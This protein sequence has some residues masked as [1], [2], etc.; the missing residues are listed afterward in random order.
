MQSRSFFQLDYAAEMEETSLNPTFDENRFVRILFRPAWR[1]S[2]SYPG[3]VTGR[4][5]PSD[6]SES[7]SMSQKTASKPT[8]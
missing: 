5:M 2:A 8:R 4:G 6:N 1:L 7:S 3:G